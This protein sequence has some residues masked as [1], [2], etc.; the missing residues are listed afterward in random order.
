[1]DCFWAAPKA[2]G[3]LS[4]YSPAGKSSVSQQLAGSFLRS[5]LPA[6]YTSAFAGRSYRSH[7]CC[8]GMRS[9]RMMNEILS[10]AKSLFNLH[11]KR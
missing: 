5:L 8:M 6:C 7:P 3:G 4:T 9:E 2:F 10:C 1:M 11:H